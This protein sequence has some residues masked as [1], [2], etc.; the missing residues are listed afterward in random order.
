L[1]ENPW[2]LWWRWLRRALGRDL[3]EGRAFELDDDWVQT[4]EG[5]AEREQ[6]PA[7]EVAA[8]LLARALVQQQSDQELEALWNEL[9]MR[10]QQVT[11]L[12]CLGLTNREIA[13]RLVVSPETVKSHIRNTLVK[14]GLH[15]KA[16]LRQRFQDWDFSA[17]DEA[18]F[19]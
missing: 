10:E 6:R 14:L 4:L 17:W 9:T 7:R 18:S 8:D 1:S 13:E 2:Q 3:D 15:G 19:R 16:E 11:A 12:T 5:L